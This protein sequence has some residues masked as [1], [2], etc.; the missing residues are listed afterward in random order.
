M[1]EKRYDELESQ[2][3]ARIE[4]NY[5]CAQCWRTLIT[6]RVKGPERM[7]KVF[8]PK[9]GEDRGFVTRDYV[10][11]RK[12]ENKLE[13]IEAA[14]NLGKILGLTEKPFNRDEAIKSMWPE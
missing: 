3:A 5:V 8:C 9:C 7:F 4:A 1:Q 12:A 13:A 6:Q 14:H 2:E 11:R 10:E